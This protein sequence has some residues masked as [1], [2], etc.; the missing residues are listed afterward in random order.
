MNPNSII[1]SSF[2]VLG[3]F[4]YPISAEENPHQHHMM[5]MQM[6]KSGMV[7]NEN[8]NT[9]PKDCTEISED[10]TLKVTAGTQF[11]EQYS[12]TVFGLDQHQWQ[13]KPCSRVTVEFTNKDEIR[14]QWMI[15]GLP[16]YLYPQGMFHIE[17][18]GSGTKTGTFIV[19]NSH[20]TYLVHCDIAQHMEKGMKA[21]LKV[22]NGRGDLPSI[23]GI[24][25][26]TFK[27]NFEILP[28]KN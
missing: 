8:K 14:H 27:D 28:Q 1:C 7:M 12:G 4:S 26:P 6:D 18:N 25:D 22:G 17:L 16:K 15:H 9:L 20:F 10:I 23:P 13:V 5:A 21:Q 3:L 24:S 11:A 2:V 19:P